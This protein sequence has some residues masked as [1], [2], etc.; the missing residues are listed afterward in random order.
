MT[1]PS[2]WDIILALEGGLDITIRLCRLFVS[3]PEDRFTVDSILER[4]EIP[5]QRRSEALE[6]IDSLQQLGLLK[7]D[8]TSLSPNPRNASFWSSL[9]DQMKGALVCRD[10]FERRIKS[11]RPR[12]VV[13]TPVEGNTFFERL[14]SDERLYVHTCPTWE[15]FQGLAEEARQRLVV[16]TPFLDRKGAETVRDMFQRTSGAVEKH[17]VLRF[18][19]DSEN[20]SVVRGLDHIAN[21]LKRLK[22][23]VHDFVMP[24]KD[25][26]KETFHAK[27]ISKDRDKAYVGS[28]NMTREYS[29]EVGLLVF[30][31]AAEGIAKLVDKVIDI[32]A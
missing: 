24:E 16:M 6:N 30:A 32:S 17:L 14:R 20:R 27:I 3:A 25:G 18:I 12:I 7:S 9:A 10:I 13:T 4:A 28:A 8:D 21:E 5:F 22:V 19:H 15:A 23:S 29:I 11:Q 2:L 1:T 31:D 26:I